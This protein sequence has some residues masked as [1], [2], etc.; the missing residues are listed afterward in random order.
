D[1]VVNGKFQTTWYVNPDDSLNSSFDL[2][3]VG[4]NSGIFASNTFTDSNPEPVQTFYIPLPEADIQT[5][6]RNLYSSVGSTINSV[7][8]ITATGD[9]SFIY[10]DH[11][12]DGYESDISNPTQSTTEIWGDGDLTN[13][14]APGTSNDLL[15]AG[16][17]ISLENTV[18]V[19]RNS[20]SSEIKFDG[21]DKI[22]SSKAI[23]V[24]RSAWATSPGSVLAGAVEVYDTAKYGTSFEVPVGEDIASNSVFQY[25]SL[26]VTAA[27]D[28]TTINVDR[29]GDGSSDITQILNEGETY[30]VNGGVN[31]GATLT[32]DNPVQAQLIT[33]D[34]GAFYESRWF[35]LY[36]RGQWSNSYYS[37]VGTTV[38][39]D[40]AKVFIY[41]PNSSAITVNYDTLNGT[42]SFSV[43]ARQAG[44]PVELYSFEMPANSG[45]HFY[46]ASEP[47]FAISAIDADTSA[48]A[49][50]D[51]GFSL[52]PESN[53]TPTAVIGW[54]P[55]S[56]TLTKNGSPVWVTAVDATRIYIDYDG[57]STT[58]NLTDPN[59]D[60]YDEHYDIS[61]LESATFFDDVNND[62]D[63]T[64][65]RIYTTD[66][67]NLTAAWGQDPARAS[68]GNPYLD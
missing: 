68:P 60:K 3:A 59:G 50:H 27:Q 26:L 38:S 56:S 11:W 51:W 35:T 24:T 22:A 4:L 13:G 16:D 46:T 10:Y 32:A 43:P 40:P 62:N 2:T 14:I 18:S 15:N 21:R 57:D 12:E 65:M 39:S 66:G 47:F 23:A 64:G 36:P 5:A 17:V 1:G 63:Q 8:S 53:L 55:G 19:P 7:I 67:T 48:N 49:T 34:I 45:A 30:F 29:D 42:G 28:S 52:V 31:A 33:G 54:G 58:G 37:P 20:N 6:L 41:N 44:Q 25:T 9:G 61:K